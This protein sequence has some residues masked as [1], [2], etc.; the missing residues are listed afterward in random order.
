MFVCCCCCCC[1]VNVGEKVVFF[2]G[3]ILTP[4]R[5]LVRHSCNFNVQL[6]HSQSTSQATKVPH[7]QPKCHTNSQSAAQTA[8]LPHKQPKCLTNS[9]SASQTVEIPPT[10]VFCPIGYF[11]E[12]RDN[13]NNIII[14]IIMFSILL[15]NTPLFR[16][17]IF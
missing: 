12:T 17:V 4:S 15:Q 6:S 3:D 11:C 2:L 5:Q 16:V 10:V 8:K 14:L 13:S 1:T 9:Q 7:K